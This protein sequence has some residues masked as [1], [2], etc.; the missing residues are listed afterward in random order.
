[1]IFYNPDISNEQKEF[2]MREVVQFVNSK[3][4][5]VADVDLSE[6]ENEDTSPTVLN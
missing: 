4:L 2:M 3:E 1:M 6:S 5:S